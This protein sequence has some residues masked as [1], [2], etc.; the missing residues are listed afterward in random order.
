MHINNLRVVLLSKKISESQW[1]NHVDVCYNFIQD[2]IEESA[3]KI[4]IIRSVKNTADQFTKKLSNRSF[5]SAAK[6]CVNE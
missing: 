5:H 2:C 3:V 6:W 4:I 1:E